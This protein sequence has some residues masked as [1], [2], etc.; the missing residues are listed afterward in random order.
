MDGTQ[1]LLIQARK[2]DKEARD[3]LVEQNIGLV[4]HV[5]RRFANRGYDMQDLFQIGCIGLLKAV[6]KF[7]ASFDVRF[8]TYAV[9]VIMGEIRRFIRDDGMMRVSRSLKQQGMLIKKSMDDFVQRW[10]REPTMEE[11]AETTGLAREDIVM[12]MEAGREVESIYRTVYQSDG[13]EIRLLDK[14]PTQRDEQ[15][16]LTNHLLLQQLLKNLREEERRLIEM[17]YFEDL[18]QT[19]TA[20]RLGI[21]QVQ[22]SRMDKRILLRMRENADIYA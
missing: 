6:D 9:P 1:V 11:L 22:V 18:T 16:E 12:A 13:D 19:M 20:K 7:D 8:S 3:K 17:R 5:T 2:G 15:E 10:G 21:S 4:R 14:L